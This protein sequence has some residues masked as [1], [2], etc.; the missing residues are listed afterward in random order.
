MGWVVNATPRP[1]YPRER[2]G[3]H[4]V[5]G[6]V[7]PQGRSGW[8]RK[9]SPPTGFDPQT[10]QLVSSLYT[11]YAIPVPYSCLCSESIQCF[12]G[13]ASKIFFCYNS[14]GSLITSMIIHNEFHIRG[15]SVHKCL[16]FS[17]FSA[18]FCTIFMSAGISTSI[19]VRV[20][21]FLGTFANL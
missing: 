10:V 5:R 18:S 6:W 7:G 1:L 16:Y 17:F 19:R 13:M 20:F 14:S 21:S 11:D 3:T 2:P 12:P 8:V 4:C 9:I 15:I